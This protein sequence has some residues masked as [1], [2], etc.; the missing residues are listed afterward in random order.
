MTREWVIIVNLLLRRGWQESTERVTAT[1]LRTAVSRA[2]VL[3]HQRV[4]PKRVYG[5][6]IKCVPPPYRTKE[7]E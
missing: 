3:A 1:L 7:A 6:S 2:L 4:R 5:V